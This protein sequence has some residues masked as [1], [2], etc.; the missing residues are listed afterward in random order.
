MA[1]PTSQEVLEDLFSRLAGR[2]RSDGATLALPGD[3]EPSVDATVWRALALRLAGPAAA[4]A[5]REAGAAVVSAQSPDGRVSVAAANRGAFGPT[6]IAVLA[7][8]GRPEFAAARSRAVAFL[9]ALSGDH[10][11]R[12]PESVIG[13]DT[14]LAGW[15]W[16]EHTFSWAEPTALAILALTSA[17]EAEHARVREGRAML[18]DRQLTAG[19]WN[20]GNA[21]VF[22]SELRPAPESTG[23]V[24]A[25]LAGGVAAS[26]VSASLSYLESV[27][28]T[29]RTPLS[30]GWALL[31]SSAWRA[32]TSA[33]E[34]TDSAGS[35]DSN[36]AIRETLARERRYGNYES[37]ELALLAVAV[38]SPRGL[39][40]ALRETA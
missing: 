33:V 40:A 20:Y 37:A 35:V 12:A 10:F 34:T 24:L 26:Q 1:D 39:V 6:A 30:L 19:G 29:L 17:G 13:M 9:L 28:P 32:Q 14:D 22:G 3:S 5:A 27:A 23:L 8:H 18:L 38:Q 15:P 2:S 36:A 16:I 21:R 4:T 25:A 11:P 7:W 31:A